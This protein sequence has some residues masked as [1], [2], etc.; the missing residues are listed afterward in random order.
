MEA[1]EL[2]DRMGH[3]VGF[4]GWEDEEWDIVWGLKAGKTRSGT[5]CGV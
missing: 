2:A 1:V 3:C 5:L 4:E